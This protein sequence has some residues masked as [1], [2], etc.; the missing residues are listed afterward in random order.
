MMILIDFLIVFGL[1]IL[2]NL[3]IYLIRKILPQKAKEKIKKI[4]GVPPS[5]PLRELYEK[6]MR[7]FD[8]HKE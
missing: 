3:L 6:E 8:E 4:M 2:E 7:R 1:I 5:S